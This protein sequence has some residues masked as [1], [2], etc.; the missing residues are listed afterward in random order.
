MPNFVHSLTPKIPSTNEEKK[1]E[2]FSNSTIR[3]VC[4]F[5]KISVAISLGTQLRS[6]SL[7]MANQ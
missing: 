3:C 7:I 1:N 2:S 4:L 6:N 5:K